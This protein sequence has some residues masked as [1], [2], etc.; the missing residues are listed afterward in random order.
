MKLVIRNFYHIKRK[1]QEKNKK[2]I[3]EENYHKDNM[4]NY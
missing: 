2:N 3:I 1:G 4:Q